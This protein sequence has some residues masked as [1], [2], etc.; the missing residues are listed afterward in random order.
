MNDLREDPKYFRSAQ[1]G[2]CVSTFQQSVCREQSLAATPH[3]PQRHSGTTGCTNKVAG[4][5]V[6][7]IEVFDQDER[8]LGDRRA[9]RR[10]GVRKGK[11][12]VG[13]LDQ[14]GGFQPA[15]GLWLAGLCTDQPGWQPELCGGGRCCPV[16][17]RAVH[18]H[19]PSSSS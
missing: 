13:L 8:H 10:Q 4:E 2:F 18:V 9:C 19:L 6:T 12:W 16:C 7:G 11:C 17:V 15:C 3:P 1:F 5:V 14:T